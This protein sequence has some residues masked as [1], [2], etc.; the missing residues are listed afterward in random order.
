[1][2]LPCFQAEYLRPC[3]ARRCGKSL[4][5]TRWVSAVTWIFVFPL[6]IHQ[7]FPGGSVDRV[8][9]RCGRNVFDLWIGKIPW[10]RKWQPTPVSL[11]GESHGQ[12]SLVT[13]S[14]WGHKESDTTEWLT[15]P[16]SFQDSHYVRVSGRWGLRV[17]LSEVGSVP[18]WGTSQ[19][20]LVLSTLWGPSTVKCAWAGRGPSPD[21]TGPL[22]SDFQPLE[23][24]DTHC[25][26]ATLSVCKPAGRH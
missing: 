8:C 24:G 3:L 22:L 23:L 14:P 16:L 25:L 11:P 18:L 2:L 20:P 21:H 10:R 19:S 13:Y 12:R 7:G 5:F 9:L 1:M 4:V 26:Y 17:E 15:L 6:K